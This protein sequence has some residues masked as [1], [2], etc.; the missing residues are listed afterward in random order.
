MSRSTCWFRDG[1]VAAVKQTVRF[2]VLSCGVDRDLHILL[3]FAPFASGLSS[4][5][6]N[7]GA[8]GLMLFANSMSPCV[9]ISAAKR[10]TVCPSTPLCSKLM[11]AEPL[12][13]TMIWSW[14][15]DQP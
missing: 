13:V 9:Y 2:F 5:L 3:P 6:N 11:P 1:E 8:L 7:V 15:G 14:R 4:A 10:S 12:P